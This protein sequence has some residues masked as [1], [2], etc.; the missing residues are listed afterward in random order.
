MP[1]PRNPCS[2]QITQDPSHVRWPTP[3]AS[4][5]LPARLTAL[6][7][8]RCAGRLDGQPSKVTHLRDRAVRNCCAAPLAPKE[9]VKSLR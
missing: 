8:N 3:P 7:R 5:Q 2:R 6:V 1:N 4:E 9:E